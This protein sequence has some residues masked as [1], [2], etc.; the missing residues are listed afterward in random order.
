MRTNEG[1]REDRVTDLLRVLRVVSV[2]R[3]FQRVVSVL[4][5]RHSVTM[6]RFSLSHEYSTFV[7]VKWCPSVIVVIEERS[8]LNDA[9]KT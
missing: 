3:V 2:H 6:L 8:V 5:A 1:C 7:V 4:S 9:K